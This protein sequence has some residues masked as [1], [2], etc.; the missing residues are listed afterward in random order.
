[1]KST[2]RLFS[3]LF[4]ALALFVGFTQVVKADEPA[5]GEVQVLISAILDDGTGTG[6]AVTINNGIH[7]YGTKINIVADHAGGEFALWIVDGMVD[8]ERAANTEFI[9]TNKLTAEAIFLSEGKVVEVYQDHSG[10]Y[11]GHRFDE[12]TTIDEPNKVGYDFAGWAE[13]EIT[14]EIE[15]LVIFRATYVLDED[16]DQVTINKNAYDFNSVVTLTAAE[17]KVW[18]E[19]DKQISLSNVYTFSA[20]TDRTLTEGDAQSDVRLINLTHLTTFRADNDTYIV[21]IAGDD[22]VEYGLEING[23]LRKATNLNKATNEFIIS[24]A[25]D[26]TR[27]VRAYMIVEVEEG[28]FETFFDRELD[29]V[30]ITHTVSF[31]PANDDSI[32]EQ[33]VNDNE[34]AIEP[35]EPERSGYIFGGWLLDGVLFDFNTPITGNI[36]LVADWEEEVVELPKLGTPIHGFGPSISDLHAALGPYA[37]ALDST[38]KGFGG[39]FVLRFTH[40]TTFEEY[41]Y[42]FNHAYNAGI[43]VSFATWAETNLPYGPYHATYKAVGDNINAVDSDWFGGHGSFTIAMPKLSNFSLTINDKMLSWIQVPNATSYDIFVDDVIFEENTT[44]ALHNISE[45]VIPKTYTIKVVAKAT[46]Y[47]N[48]EAT[49]QHIV[50]SDEAE[51]LSTPTNLS[52]DGDRQILTWD[53]DENAQGYEVRLDGVT[54]T[55]SVAEYD[56]GLFYKAGTFNVEVKALGDGGATY[57][58]SDWAVLEVTISVAL[59]PLAISPVVGNFSGEL[60]GLKTSYAGGHRIVDPYDAPYRNQEGYLGLLIQ[61]YSPSMEFL[62]ETRTPA[63]WHVPGAAPGTFASFLVEGNIVWIIAEA[64]PD[65]GFAN[66]EPLIVV[67]NG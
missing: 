4:I 39:K 46:G 24:M 18:F 14:R 6:E 51:Q 32:F 61:V 59:T 63:T 1:M 2:K 41:F 31:N 5:E 57:I 19:D 13:V 28:V 8:Y 11:L 12:E 29:P 44:E 25:S 53:L 10:K 54:K 33:E 65:S 17:G 43:G 21:Q 50:Q 58:D 56:L 62:S 34:L 30:Q 67:L 47:Q 38:G 26:A 9:V 66:S 20:L 40:Q 52:Y 64:Q 37:E 23:T 48:S 27:E 15:G 42:E 49:I 3:L 16:K 60:S 22:I 55:V 7:A 35:E 36:T 45:L